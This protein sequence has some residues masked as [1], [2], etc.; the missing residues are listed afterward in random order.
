MRLGRNPVIAVTGSAGKSTTKEMIASILR[1]KWK[2]FKSPGNQNFFTH[3]QKYAKRFKSGKYRAAVLEYGMSRGGHIRKHCAILKPDVSVVT[4]IGTAHLGS[5]GGDVKKLIRAKSE[6]I[7]YMNRNGLAVYNL[8]D[9]N[10]R[11][12]PRGQFAGKLVTVGIVRKADYRA[13][14]VHY[15]SGGMGFTVKLHGTSQHFFIPVYGRHQVYNALCAVAVAN[16]LGFSVRDIRLG[17]RTFQRMRSRMAVHRV[18][19]T[20]T[21]IDDSFSANPNAAKAAVDVLHELG[22]RRRAKTVAVLGSMLA[23]GKYTVAGHRDV[24]RHLAN[25]SIDALYTY[26][27]F[28]QYTGKAAVAAGLPKKHW[29]HF[30]RR[31]ALHQALTRELQHRSVILVKGSHGVRM[32]DT[33]KYLVRETRG[34]IGA[35]N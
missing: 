29:H 22:K 27:R 19:S 30:S 21:L 20:I 16:E 26:G 1:R 7:R 28:T 35:K 4:N 18:S 12:M 13:S 15:G 8:D 5:F 17:L 10:S 33:F 25:K 2:V 11:A 24:G 9:G 3:T 31:D 23:L 32:G 34:Q 6:L 14:D